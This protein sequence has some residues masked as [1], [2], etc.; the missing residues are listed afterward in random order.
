[1]VTV[2]RALRERLGIA[3]A[4]TAFI[5]AVTAAIIFAVAMFVAIGALYAMD[6]LFA[7]QIRKDKTL[8]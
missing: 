4:L 5:M 8:R 2:V 1:M 6:S 3:L 7:R